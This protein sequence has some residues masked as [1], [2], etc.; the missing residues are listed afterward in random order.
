MHVV[1]T[2]AIAARLNEADKVVN[3]SSCM[4]AT[5]ALPPSAA[6]SS[7]KPLSCVSARDPRAQNL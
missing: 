1:A 2:E 3:Q 6:E 5:D 7:R 4:Q